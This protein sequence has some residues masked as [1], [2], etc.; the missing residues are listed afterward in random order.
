MRPL[1]RLALVYGAP[2][3][4]GGLGVQVA[5]AIQGLAIEGVELHAFGPGRADQWPL[6]GP[7][8]KIFW[9]DAP[10]GVSRFK[11]R[12]TP[13]RWRQGQLVFE[14]C[15]LVGSWAAEQIARLQPDFCYL[16]T[17]VALESLKWA[18]RASIPTVL[19]SP[20]GHIRNFRR[21]YDEE[22]ARWCSATYLGHPT[23]AMV[24]RVENEYLLAS[25]IRVSSEWSRRSMLSNGVTSK[26]IG[27][28]EQPVNLLRF[29]PNA[30]PPQVEGP[31]RVCYV[32][33]LD[34]RKGYVYLLRAAKTLGADSVDLEIVG[35][36]GDSSSRKLFR[37]ESAGLNLRC[38][39]GDP[40]AAYQRAELFVMPTLEDGSPF[41]VAEA[42]ASGLPAIVTDC[43]GAAEWVRPGRSG[44]VVRGGDAGALAG[45]IVDATQ[46]R[47]DLR[48]MGQRA[49]EDTER[50]AGIHCL[51]PLR[52]WIF[53]EGAHVA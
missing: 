6:P 15:G 33:S 5:N 12:Y 53:D 49:R 20:N 43:C 13:L 2:A 8:P 35:A 46:C 41:A 1:K 50:R 42:M 17:Q 28:F 14:D 11:A 3:G 24:E 19:E 44:W 16:F 18:A 21:V 26:T 9:H 25:R 31:L 32:G 29:T 37:R 48:A 10:S 52:E 7:A 23:A 34:L 51:T 30:S 47:N 45:A 36:T 27:M 39:P 22:S 4:V 40:I 38:A